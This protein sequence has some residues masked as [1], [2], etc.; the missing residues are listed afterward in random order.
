MKIAAVVVTYNRIEL[1][2]ECLDSILAQTRPADSLIVIDNASDDGTNELFSQG[3]KYHL[4]SVQ[5]KRM[6]SNLGGAGGFYEGIRNAYLAGMD[7]IWIMDDD[8]IPTPTALEKLVE[9]LEIVKEEPSFLASTVYGKYMDPMN[10][11]ELDVQKANNGY[12]YW[13]EYLDKG[14]IKICVASF[15]SILINKNAISKVGLPY[16]ELF[17]WGDDSEYTLRLSKYYGNAYMCGCS[18][19]IHKR[20][21]SKAITIDNAE[22]PDRIRMYRYSYRNSLLISGEY[23]GGARTVCRKIRQNIVLSIRILFD[24]RQ[25]YRFLKYRTIHRGIWEYIIGT[26]NREGFRD[27][28]Q[29]R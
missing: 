2:Q 5:Y 13:Y 23:R 14:I 12:P 25:K 3:A 26:Y 7:W 29:I 4:P 28:F 22:D 24:K 17:I 18:V 21:V 1:L 15:V 10:V 20:T 11:P 27:R 16:K 6:S 9:A 8:T 19:V